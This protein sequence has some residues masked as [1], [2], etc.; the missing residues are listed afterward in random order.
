MKK[1]LALVLVL[2]CAAGMSACGDKSGGTALEGN[3]QT[4]TLLLGQGVY[5]ALED[6]WAAFDRLSTERKMLSSHMPGNCHENFEDWAACEDFLGIDIPNPLEDMGSLEK[7]TYV[8][9]PEGFQG[10]PH[11]R[12]DWY[13]TR[14]GDVER[15]S[16]QCGYMCNGFRVTLDARLCAGNGYAHGCGGCGNAPQITEDSGEQYCASSACLTRGGVQYNL[17]VVGG[18]GMQN[19]VRETLEELLSGF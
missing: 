1:L 17:R 5:D 14:D 15:L 11:V 10:A 7:G 4:E 18:A 13:G 12:V 16:V 2:A 19:E 6:E 8:G 9:M 3:A